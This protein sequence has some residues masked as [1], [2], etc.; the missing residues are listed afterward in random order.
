MENLESF[1]I[2][3]LKFI[4]KIVYIILNYS[5]LIKPRVFIFEHLN[6]FIIYNFYSL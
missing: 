3:N 6:L 2:I 4:V 1:I 5:H